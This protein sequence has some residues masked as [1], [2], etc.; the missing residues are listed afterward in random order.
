[1][2]A[3]VFHDVGDI[4]LD[5]V[6]EPRIE[7]PTDAIVR[8]TASAICGTDLHFVRGTVSEMKPGTIL[9]HEGVG[10]V[11]ELGEDVRNLEIGDRVVIPSTIACG[12]CSY[13]RAGYYAQCDTA[14]PNGKA[15]GTSF[16]GGPAATGP[17]NGLQAEKARIPFANIGLVK[18]PPEISDDQAILLSD[19]FPTGYFGA[20]MAGIKDGDTVAV[21]GCGP[22]GL[23]AIASARL[24]G[25]GRIFAIDQFDDRL[26]MAR[27]QGA[28]VI[29]FNR[30]DPVEA[31]KRLTDGIGVD[32]AIDAVGVD[33]EHGLCG[34]RSEAKPVSD[35]PQGA[36]GSWKPGDAPAQA[37]EWA[38]QSLA[39]A[40]T[41]SIIG[42]YPPDAMTF[43]I[44]MAMNR[45]LTIT[46]GNC[47]H[48]K[49]IP[50]LI[51][52]VLAKRIDPAQ[53]LTQ[54]KPMNDVIAAF[55]AFDRRENGWVKVELLPQSTRSDDA[56]DSARGEERLDDAIADTFPASDPTTMQNP[57][58]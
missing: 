39:K 12:N 46:M 7:A 23:F 20:D 57:K 44:G 25:A 37:L 31:I 5:E 24:M 30:E 45:N 48:R 21:F 43:P 9:G 50:K 51:E 2:K 17:F 8:I 27:K 29:D 54:V 34:H 1:M 11:E 10:I 41:L 18:L 13:C 38:V 55:K 42:V 15:A 36:D 26:R 28:E 52:M 4:R 22:V 53:I 6:P 35:Q 19:I 47:H 49:Y 3:V 56:A 14:N 58:R 16:F 32:R 33:A 40:G